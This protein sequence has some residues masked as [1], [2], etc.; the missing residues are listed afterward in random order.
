MAKSLVELQLW[1]R[2]RVL[3]SSQIYKKKVQL[4][5]TKEKQ[6]PN[7]EKGRLGTRTA[8]KMKMKWKFKTLKA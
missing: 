7:G 2:V 5:K 1:T 8:H 4:M 6:F 3:D